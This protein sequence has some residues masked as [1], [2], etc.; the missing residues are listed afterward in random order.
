[1]S[2]PGAVAYI[3]GVQTNDTVVDSTAFAQFTKRQRFPMK[4]SG[5]IAGLGTSD[6]IQLKK[7]GVVSALEVRIAGHVDVV[8]TGAVTP[9]WQWPYNLVKAFKVSI[10]GQSTL[11]DAPGLALKVAEFAGDSDLNDRG[12]S[13]HIGSSTA[14]SQGTLSLS[15]EDWGTNAANY[16]SPAVEVGGAA[17]YT[18]DLTWL[19]PLAANQV[20]LIGS[21]FGQSQATNIN[22]EVVYSSESELFTIAAGGSVDLSALKLD[23]TGIAY[24][25]PV[26]NGKMIVPDLSQ[27][28]GLNTT[29][30]PVTA[31]GEKE[32]PLPGTGTGRK[33]L[34][35]WWN[36]YS[37]GAPLAMTEANYST[38]GY[39]YGGNVAPEA[40][41][42]GSKLRALNERQLN[43]DIGKHWGIGM[44][45]F[46]SQF[47]LR[48]LIDLGETSDF[49]LY[50][51]PVA[52]PTTGKAFITQET[53][54]AA[55]VGA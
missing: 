30:E 27:L 15:H 26:V 17:A 5:A 33:L 31:S 18:V 20:N 44:W 47:A 25:I 40:Y 1:M 29:M 49:R 53:V 51:S 16:L 34:R 21:I 37:S 24:S 13:R 2:N 46:A 42:N 52:A 55:A 54:F 10:N 8:V 22:V 14:D 12:V 35:M 38:C 23:V 7:T 45:D 48:D 6:Q 39:K 41:P 28:H 32:Y 50:F 11:I 9:T 3:Q 19:I 36:L 43:C 4:T